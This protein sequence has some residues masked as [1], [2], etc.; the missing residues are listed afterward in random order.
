MK[1]ALGKWS[2]ADASRHLN[3][4][5]A[6]AK[7][8]LSLTL[9]AIDRMTERGLIMADVLHVIKTGFVY[10][11]PEATTRPD[12]WKYRIEGLSPNSGGRHVRVVVI[13]GA[14]PSVKVV[15]VMWKDE[16]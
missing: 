11:E 2:P 1:S 4:M 7:L 9:H 10:E 6:D 3:A 5:A 14:G 12:L 8:D 13:P 15:T 16:R